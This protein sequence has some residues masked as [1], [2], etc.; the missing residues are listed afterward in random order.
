MRDWLSEGST[1]S[2]NTDK[3]EKTRRRWDCETLIQETEGSGENLK[4][5][6]HKAVEKKLFYEPVQGPAHKGTQIC[7]VTV[8]S[9][10]YTVHQD[11]VKLK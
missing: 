2:S 1:K 8:V 9:T 11:F 7:S 3:A 5:C 6:Q 10:M 4:G